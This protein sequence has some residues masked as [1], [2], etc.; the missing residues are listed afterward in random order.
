MRNKSG[1][2]IAALT[3]ACL[4]LLCACG[5]GGTS[6][7][8]TSAGATT[9]GDTAQTLPDGS[10]AVFP[11]QAEEIT[12]ALSPGQAAAVTEEELS[13][14]SSLLISEAAAQDILI[15]DIRWQTELSEKELKAGLA[16]GSIDAA[17]L[18]EER[19]RQYE[20]DLFAAAFSVAK[21]IRIDPAD[22]AT[23]NKGNGHAGQADETALTAHGLILAGPSETGRALAKKVL[24]GQALTAKELEDAV[25][26]V[27][28]EGSVFGYALP[29]EW[30]NEGF[31]LRVE[32]L[33]QLKTA[34]SYLQSFQLLAAEEADIITVPCDL[35]MDFAER[36]KSSRYPEDMA[37]EGSVYE[38]TTVIGVTK[39]RYFDA[40]VVSKKGV[41]GDA[42]DKEPEQFSEAVLRVLQ[43]LPEAEAASA[44]MDRAGHTGYVPAE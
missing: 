3:A 7:G 28:D 21:G 44:L 1:R 16:E 32:L 34:E 31:G 13:A 27:T 26:C 20:A 8:G 38:E 4:L 30:L 43:K 18:P 39:G 5:G 12:V 6:S 29:D 14:L 36:W 15:S 24:E 35:R 11:L 42:A 17:L 10:E 40:V 22:A 23:W 37:R 9:Q 41:F 2:A 33:P 19:Y 25:W